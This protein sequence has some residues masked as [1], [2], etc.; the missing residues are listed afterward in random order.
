MKRYVKFLSLK[1]DDKLIAEYCRRHQ[2]DAIWPEIIKGIKQV[3]IPA[4]DI[5]ILGNKLVMIVETPD[6]LDIDNAMAQLATLPRQQEWEDYMSIFQQAEPG[7]T[8]ADKWQ[9]MTQIF[10]LYE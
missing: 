1:N 2:P 5:Y 8:S 4:M 7:V 6:T 9:P 10:H 3:G